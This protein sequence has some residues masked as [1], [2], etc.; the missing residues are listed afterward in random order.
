M[1]T[2]KPRLGGRRNQCPSCGLLFNGIDPF[3]AHRTGPFG[4]PKNPQAN[5]RCLTQAEML[6][7][8]MHL[9]A[10]GFWSERSMD[11]KALQRFK[12][13]EEV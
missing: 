6:A 7:S 10:D 13:L 11:D 12:Q 4:T 1:Q 8:G 3:D 5:R 2:T 9:G